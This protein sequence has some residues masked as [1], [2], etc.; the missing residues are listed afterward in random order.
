MSN[1][2]LNSTTI[3]GAA[4]FLAGVLAMVGA[5]P[6]GAQEVIVENA[7]LAVGAVT[8]LWGVVAT[9]KGALR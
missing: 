7:T 5:I 6:E 4:T 8:T 1:V 3:R 2:P 9:I